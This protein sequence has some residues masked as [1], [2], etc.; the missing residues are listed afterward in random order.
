M[1]DIYLFIEHVIDSIE[2]T[3]WFNQLYTYLSNGATLL[4]CFYLARKK[5]S[6]DRNFLIEQKIFQ[7]LII[8]Y[9]KSFLDLP[10]K[11]YTIIM[12]LAL[13]K[14]VNTPVLKKSLDDIKIFIKEVSL[15]SLS[16][17]QAF[18]PTNNSN[19]NEYL[20][21]YEDAITN[22]LTSL[23]LPNSDPTIIMSKFDSIS[24]NYMRFILN[25]VKEKS[26][27][28]LIN[29]KDPQAYTWINKVIDKIKSIF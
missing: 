17:F 28:E 9:Q 10:D 12:K 22:L 2:F 16:K 5:I 8:P 4:I 3:D 15:K 14:K 18:T 24:I 7:D 11:I 13:R 6:S 20:D 21:E 1:L 27:E 26:N 19:L 23:I 25:F 29:R